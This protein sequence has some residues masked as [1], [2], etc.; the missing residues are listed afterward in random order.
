[1]PK[2]VQKQK[3]KSKGGRRKQK[4]VEEVKWDPMTRKEYLTGFH[5]R[6][7]ERQKKY[8]KKKELIL[9][10]ERAAIRK[11]KKEQIQ[12]YIDKIKEIEHYEEEQGGDG[13]DDQD[14]TS[15]A[16]QEDQ[17]FETHSNIVTELIRVSYN[18][19]S[20]VVYNGNVINVGA[21]ELSKYLTDLPPT[22]HYIDSIDAQ[23][24]LNKEINV[25]SVMV[26]VS[27]SVTYGRDPKTAVTRLF[28]QKF[29]IKPLGMDAATIES[30][31]FR[32]T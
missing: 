7:L 11:M 30:D 26:T 25:E 13:D 1:M 6:K 5:K 8:E 10:E 9:K 21:N 20:A 4:I 32:F 14:N 24:L 19:G 29:V 17:E 18:A 22:R 12:E 16:L 27:G 3:F 28:T 23:P 15:K 31:A 2:Q